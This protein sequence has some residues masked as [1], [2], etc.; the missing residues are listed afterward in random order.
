LTGKSKV[1]LSGS[2]K[3]MT[4]LALHL[5]EEHPR[6]SKTLKLKGGD[7]KRMPCGKKRPVYGSRGDARRHGAITYGRGKFTVR[8]VT[9]GYTAYERI[10]L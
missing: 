1:I 7:E 5:K 6:Y 3:Q 4:D 10:K 9:G 8:K 2:E